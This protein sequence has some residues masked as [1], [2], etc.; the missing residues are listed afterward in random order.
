MAP[1]VFFQPPLFKHMKHSN[2]KKWKK[3]NNF[4]VQLF[5]LLCLSWRFKNNQPHTF[6]C[7]NI[8]RYKS[9]SCFLIYNRVCLY[10]YM[11][12]K[13]TNIRTKIKKVGI[14]MNKKN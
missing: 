10:I 12:N 5:L 1:L 8:S 9:N 13:N 6:Y 11:K 7:L 14:V 2:L 3:Q 4:H